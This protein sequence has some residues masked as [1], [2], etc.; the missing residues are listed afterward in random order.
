MQQGIDV[1][2]LYVQYENWTMSMD[3][4][5]SAAG[6]WKS[7]VLCFAGSGVFMRAYNKLVGVR[8][9]L[10]RALAR[11]V[12]CSPVVEFA[13]S[14][15][16]FEQLYL[17]Y[18]C[19][20]DLYI[21][22]NPQSLPVVAWAAKLVGTGY[23]FDSEDLHSGQ[24]SVTE[25]NSV[26]YRLL[27]YLEE[28]YLK[29]CA[30]VTAASPGIAEMLVNRYGIKPPV[31][32]LNTFD[33]LVSVDK[34]VKPQGSRLTLYWYSQIV[35]QGRGLEQV[36]RAIAE[37]PDVELHIRGYVDVH[38]TGVFE[39]I[40]RENNACSRVI[41]HNTVTPEELI[42]AA[43]EYGVGLCLEEKASMNRDVC[44]ANKIM[45]YIAAGIPV[46]ASDTAGHRYVFDQAVGIGVMVKL[47]EID[48]LRDA[49]DFF[50]DRSR[51]KDIS[52]AVR[53]AAKSRWNWSHD[54]KL[55]QE[56]VLDTLNAGK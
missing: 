49:I 11:F 18:T 21:G 7:A 40:I 19:R 30:Y 23:A 15:Y 42:M 51:I 27:Q 48:Q 20:A 34:P 17:A 12:S 35:S 39:Q 37:M 8:R 3:E 50:R 5:I 44:I 33:T 1:T 53:K 32:I 29:G 28:R 2:V 10:F 24:F 38:T 36:I 16:F 55:L 13:Y 45:T 47:E 43:S 26:E 9:I 56:L 41:F 14:R 22:H 4:D 54:K 52:T 46:I 31:T 25:T 6:G